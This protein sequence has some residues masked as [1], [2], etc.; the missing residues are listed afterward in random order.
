M[1]QPRKD[2]A[3]PKGFLGAWL[4]EW[5]KIATA[6]TISFL[7][8]LVPTAFTS[9]RNWL[10]PPPVAYPVVCTAE[11]VW[12]GGDRRLV[13]IYL[14]NTLNEDLTG[15]QLSER[16]SAALGKAAKGA[17]TAV[18]FPY[19]EGEPRAVS[20]VPDVRFN[21]GKGELAV[22]LTDKGVR[23]QPTR[24]AALAILRANVTFPVED[25]SLEFERGAKIT[26]GMFDLEK[27]E[28]GC[29]TR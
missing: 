20:A 1:P 12:Q 2:K 22:L 21:R 6:L 4:A 7:L 24:M 18:V 15:E 27:P 5:P 10:W 16:L 28:A 11:P 29:F 13:E 9:V 3:G 14:I 17:S 19:Q 26:A 25:D 23:V 8:F